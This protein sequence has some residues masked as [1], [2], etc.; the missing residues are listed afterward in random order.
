MCS[1]QR[2]DRN[3]EQIRLCASDIRVRHTLAQK[4]V[5]GVF[6]PTYIQSFLDECR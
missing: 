1:T 3:I 5:W 4:R 2:K 6:F